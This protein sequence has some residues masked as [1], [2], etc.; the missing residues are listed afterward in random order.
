MA[1][2]IYKMGGINVENDV[3]GERSVI[4]PPPTDDIGSTGQRQATVYRN[5]L[6]EEIGH[7]RIVAHHLVLHKQTPPSHLTR[8]ELNTED[9]CIFSVYFFG[10]FFLG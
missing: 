2:L 4:P 5:R 7:V 1:E 6:A 10:L 8:N 3:M 9:A